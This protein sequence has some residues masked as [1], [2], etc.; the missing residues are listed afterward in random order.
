MFRKFEEIG[1]VHDLCRELVSFINSVTE[2]NCSYQ[3]GSSN[4]FNIRDE[5]NIHLINISENSHIIG[6]TIFY[7]LSSN[8]LIISDFI[9]SIFD[10]DIISF[11]I[12]HSDIE[13]YLDDLTIKNYHKFLIKQK[14]SEFNI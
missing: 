2:L 1:V 7:T 4:E 11:Y 13:S 3:K 10:S 12:K 5:D 8:Y 9:R 6:I 14:A